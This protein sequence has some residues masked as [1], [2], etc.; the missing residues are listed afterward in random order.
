MR[1]L[2]LLFLAGVV[3]AGTA[4]AQA[5]APLPAP[6][7][8]VGK[9][10]QAPGTFAGGYYP[11]QLATHR[12]HRKVGDVTVAPGLALGSWAGFSG[13][14]AKAM[15]MGDLVLTAAELAPVQ[16]ALNDQ[17]V[18]ITA[19]HNHLVGEEPGIIYMHFG[20]EGPALDLAQR[21]NNRAL[22]DRDTPPGRRRQAGGPGH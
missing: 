20:A 10:L 5:P 12:P 4:E 18:G 1:I 11:L 17:H 8:S 22:P 13:T 3:W 7:D 2:T 21:L 16:Q 14:A 19:V 9:T 15:V 6:W